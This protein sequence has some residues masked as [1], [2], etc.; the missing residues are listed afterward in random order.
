MNP[1]TCLYFTDIE[2]HHISKTFAGAADR[3]L[4]IFLEGKKLYK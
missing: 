4:K 3:N 2:M 1:R